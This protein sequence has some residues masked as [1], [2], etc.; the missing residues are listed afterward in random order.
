M[1]RECSV[2][3]CTDLTRGGE[4]CNKHRLRMQRHGTLDDPVRI[5]AGQTCS[6]PDCT[7]SALSR[8]LCPSHYRRLRRHG[9]PTRVARRP[10]PKTPTYR[11]AHN[12]VYQAYGPASDHLCAGCFA[13]AQEWSYDHADPDEL[14]GSLGGAVM[15]YSLNLDHYAPLC[16]KCHRRADIVADE[17]QTR[18]AIERKDS[19]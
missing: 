19:A 9:D 11:Q 17:Q 13:P 1:P 14:T 15:A 8:G 4:L 5:N 2:A 10:S 18:L 12:L 6:I 7:E 16:R 3:G